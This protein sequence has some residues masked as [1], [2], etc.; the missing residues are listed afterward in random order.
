M[1]LVTLSCTI[2]FKGITIPPEAN[3]FYVA[4]FENRAPQAP[5]DV[6]QQF[7]E[8]LKFKL[9]NETRLTWNDEDPDLE[10][11]GQI[12][13]YQVTAMAPQPNELV[14]FNRLSLAIRV[15]YTNNMEE[16]DTWD[17]NFSFYQD[18]GNDVNLLDVQDQLIET[19][20]TQIAEDIFNKAFTSW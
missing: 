12:S 9:L 1:L 8:L 14:G 7:S 3:T 5:V 6:G 17:N 13:R 15:N 19:I 10:F 20:H 18:F 16:E 11:S 2:N 4:E